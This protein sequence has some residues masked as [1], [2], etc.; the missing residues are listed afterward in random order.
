MFV[1]KAGL[2]NNLKKCMHLATMFI[3]QMEI[4]L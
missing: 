3:K 4:F 1:A 2:I